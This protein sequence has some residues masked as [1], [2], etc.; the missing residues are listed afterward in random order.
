M[1]LTRSR[2]VTVCQ[3]SLATAAVAVLAVSAAG[4]STLRIVH[5]TTPADARPSSGVPA[6]AVLPPVSRAAA[7]TWL[8][9]PG[10]G[11][12]ERSLVAGGLA[13]YVVR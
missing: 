6:R 10:A 13:T 5:P 12:L 11:A 1:R 8:A 3:Q 2:Y 4:V 9:P 7:G